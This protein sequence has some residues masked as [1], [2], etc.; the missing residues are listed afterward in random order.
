MKNNI[1][2]NTR[3]L[4]KYMINNNLQ[5]DALADKCNLTRQTVHKAL[6]GKP[7]GIY[8]ANK[9]VF[10]MKCDGDDLVKRCD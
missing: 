5:V 1:Y 8:T 3:F 7:V 10:G 6:D 9:L 4:I 2:I